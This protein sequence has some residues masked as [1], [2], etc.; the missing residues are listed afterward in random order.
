MRSASIYFK[1]ILFYLCSMVLFAISNAI[2]KTISFPE[3]FSLVMATLLTAGLIY[4]FTHRDKISLNCIGLCFKKNDISKFFV[5]ICIGMLMVVIMTL[6]IANLTSIDFQKSSTFQFHQLTLYIPLF[7]FVAIREELVF[8]TYILWRL[9]DK[10]GP[11][12]SMVCITVIFIAEH[13]IGGSTLKNSILGAGLGAVLF[14]IATL[15]TG[16]IAM[17]TGLHFAWNSVHWLLGYKD[18]TGVFIELVSKGNEGKDEIISYAT[19]IIVM[20][21]G[22]LIVSQLIKPQKRYFII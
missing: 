1:I 5:G 14:G 19:Y 6:I 10:I 13:I 12:I 15:K 21:L 2:C 11:V 18:N 4:I 8:R 20:L 7:F 22:I 3:L 16:N 9:N 17:S